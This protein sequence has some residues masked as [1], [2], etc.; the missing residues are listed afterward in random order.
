[1][2]GDM[3]SASFIL[4]YRR[5]VIL[6]THCVLWALAYLSAF[7]LRFEFAVPPSFAEQ[8]LKLFPILLVL[9]LVAFFAFQMFH[10]LWRYTGSRDLVGL[11][12]ATTTGTLLFVVAIV[13]MGEQFPRSIFVIEWLLAIVTVGGVRF[14]IRKLREIAEQVSSKGTRRNLLIVG[15]GDEGEMLL[16]EL[17]RTHGARYQP[18]AFLDD[19]KAKHGAHIHGVPVVGGVDMLS[20]A[21]ARLGID[22]LILATP[23]A[24]GRSIRPIIETCGTAGVVARIL[25]AI[26]GLIDGRVTVNQIRDVAIEDLLGRL[27]VELDET[28]MASF[29]R[30][31]IVLVTGAGGSIGA[32]LCRQV[33]R[34]GPAKLMLVE[35]AEN[36][37][38]AIHREIV[39]AHP[40][41]RLIPVLADICDAARMASIFDRRC[42]QVIYH[43]AA[44]KHVAMCESNPGET[45]ENNVLG[46]KQLA[47]L[48]HERG[49]EH[50]VMISTDKAVN[51]TSMMGAAKRAAEIYIQSLSQR[52]QTRFVTVRFGNVLDSNGS[53][54]P[55]FREQVRRGGPVTVTHPDMKRYF[56]T[57][58]EACQLVMQAGTMGR[59]GEIFVLDMGEPIKIVDLAR[60]LIRLSGLAPGDDV[61]IVF[62]GMRAGEKLS[63]E[64]MVSAENADRTKHHKIFVGRFRPH[65]WA[66]VLKDMEDLKAV[67]HRSDAE[68]RATFARIIPEY[69]P[70]SASEA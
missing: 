47:D 21:I 43:A 33:A 17:Q 56:M 8:G 70:T 42:P 27:P 60:D 48:S 41:L 28:A 26:D 11:V 19:D 63:E 69:Q 12:K 5:L 14:S 40:T 34:H 35:R 38:F 24:T 25:P 16:R 3:N 62:T 61:E 2:A 36:S 31:K 37:L 13:L 50:F 7:L 44:H 23:S 68:I 55:I 51:P 64:F 46:T 66:D 49:V 9:R 53:V 65:E 30:G 6:A 52:S 4:R 1:M 67:A 20:E 39:G 57:I 58:A 45:I 10:G 15:A 54:I 32:E 59:G 29:V 22:E 18:V